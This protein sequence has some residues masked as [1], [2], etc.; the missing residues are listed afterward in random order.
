GTLEI[1]VPKGGAPKVRLPEA[2]I[3]EI[4]IGE[5]AISQVASG[6]VDLDEIGLADVPIAQ[7]PGF[8]Q[9][10]DDLFARQ[11]H[12]LIAFFAHRQ[13]ILQNTAQAIRRATSSIR[14]LNPV[15]LSYQDRTLRR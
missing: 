5:I 8:R 14:Q 11:G 6:K 3:L 1:G 10:L 7:I 13:L 4:G 9:D 12:E 15:S 2:A